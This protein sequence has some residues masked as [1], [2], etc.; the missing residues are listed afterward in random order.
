MTTKEQEIADI[1]LTSIKDSADS[2]SRS[3]LITNYLDFIRAVKLR[4]EVDRESVPQPIII[5]YYQH[6]YQPYPPHIGTTCCAGGLASMPAPV[7][8]NT[9]GTAFSNGAPKQS[10]D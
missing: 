10:T 1:L 6:P 9:Y 4:M 8:A 7:N 5:P 2:Q 3:Y